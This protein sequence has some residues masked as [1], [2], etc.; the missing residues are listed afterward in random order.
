MST[1]NFVRR[2]LLTLSTLQILFVTFTDGQSP[3]TNQTG[4]AEP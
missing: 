4:L 1:Q 2:M 3:S